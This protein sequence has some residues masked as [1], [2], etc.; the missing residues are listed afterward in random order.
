MTD[1]RETKTG[2]AAVARGPKAL[3]RGALI[4]ACAL[5]LIGGEVLFFQDLG[6][7]Y[8]PGSGWSMLAGIVVIA[9]SC[10][11]YLYGVLRMALL[12][13][14]VL[15][16]VSLAATLT[17][18]NLALNLLIEASFGWVESLRPIVQ[19]GSFINGI[20][21][22]MLVTCMNL[23]RAVRGRGLWRL[24][25]AWLGTV[26]FILVF[27]WAVSPLYRD[28]NQTFMLNML[29]SSLYALA[30]WFSITFATD[31]RR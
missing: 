30:A 14:I 26:G 17:L 15:G 27:E 23:P 1:S 12:W 21:L 9:L 20:L 4:G 6:S 24:L 22:L 11:V 25:L 2:Q 3:A 5:A 29:F 31:G 18:G 13:S 19:S 10:F 8:N 16:L 7:I 28:T